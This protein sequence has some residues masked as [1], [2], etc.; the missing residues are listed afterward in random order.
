MGQN[1]SLRSL[2]R[3]ADL[4]PCDAAA[5]FLQSGFWGAFKARSG[6][7][8]RG[9]LA[10]WGEG[11][12]RPLLVLCRA[13]RRFGFSFA[14]VPWGPEL[15]SWAAADEG[16]R[17]DA[18][19]ELARDLRSHL[20]RNTACVRFDPPWYTEG[21]GTP[22]PAL[23]R[24]FIR[25]AMDVQPPDTALLSLSPP[26][27]AI[28]GAMKPKWR[29]NI[30]LA[31]KRGVQVR[32]G[33]AE[34][35]PVFYAL[36]QE[37]ARRDRIAIH[38]GGYYH[39]LF[40]LCR[41][42][43]AAPDIRLYIASHEGEDIAAV[44]TLFRAGQAYYLYGAS[45]DRKRNLMAPY[46]LQWKALGDAKAGGC[47]CYDFFGIPPHEDTKHPMSGLYRFKTGFGGRIIHRSGSWDY[48]Y[49]PLTAGILRAAEGLRKQLRG[50]KK[51]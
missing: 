22:P 44:I 47:G 31:E 13:F 2:T 16:R 49:R 48:A 14:Y 21:A 26:E 40:A 38:S 45:S 41:E 29:Y 46:L 18:L 12:A 10:E 1:R 24:P 19:V 42:Y 36:F 43:P 30:R 25:A 11:E 32:R 23:D 39:T 9:F 35:T 15:P 50:I 5:S 3:T 4:S 34:E 33:G 37:T 6:W 17:R 20:P 27:E 8:A 51:R 7:T 28:L